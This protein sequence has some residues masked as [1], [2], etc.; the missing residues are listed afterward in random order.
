MNI[1]VSA[2]AASALS[3]AALLFA[4]AAHAG[5]DASC[6]FHGS[7]PAAEATVVGCA[8][9]YKNQ[10]VAG[11]KVDKSWQDIAKPEKVEQIEGKKGKEW[12]ITFRNPAVTDKA[13]DTLYLFYS[14]PGNFIAANHTGQ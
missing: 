1:T 13:K 9:Q 2:F 11:S 12:R 8:T 4:P 7:K 3:A 5:A 14:L 6:H 10:L